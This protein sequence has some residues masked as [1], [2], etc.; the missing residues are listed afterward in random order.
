MNGLRSTGSA[1][2]NVYAQIHILP[3]PRSLLPAVLLE[4][5]SENTFPHV[6]F[7]NMKLEDSSNGYNRA[8]AGLDLRFEQDTDTDTKTLGHQYFP[9]P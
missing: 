1:H 3:V 6:P 5:H 4:H 8:Q 2:T 7:P 9:L